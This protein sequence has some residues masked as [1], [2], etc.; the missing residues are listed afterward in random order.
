VPQF[1]DCICIEQN[2]RKLTWKSAIERKLRQLTSVW[3]LKS[4]SDMPI[5]R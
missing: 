4:F 1:V 3:A 5:H 2:G